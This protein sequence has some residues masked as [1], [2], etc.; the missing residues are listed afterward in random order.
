MADD[1]IQDLFGPFTFISDHCLTQYCGSEKKSALN[2]AI[3]IMDDPRFRMHGP[4]HHFLVPAV[5]LTEACKIQGRTPE[6]FSLCLNEAQMRS[7]NVLKAFCGLYGACGAAIGIG[8]YG[9]VLTGTTPY[10]IE[11]WGIVNQGTAESL[12]EMAKLNGPRCCKRNTFV[13]L[14]YAI[15]FSR[16][17]FGIDMEESEIKKCHY[18]PMNKECKKSACPFFPMNTEEMIENAKS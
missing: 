1:P 11:T 17:H 7:K 10:S 8:I 14:Y 16:Q 4:E 3:Q 5:L 2:L 9:S 13:A 12:G 6:E 18:Y 15:G